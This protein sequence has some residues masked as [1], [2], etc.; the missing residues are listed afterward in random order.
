MEHK[1]G[2]LGLEKRFTYNE[3]VNYISKDPDKI[4][5]PNRTAT[6]DWDSIFRVNFDNTGQALSQADEASHSTTPGTPPYVP[7]SER[8]PAPGPPPDD[9]REAPRPAWWQHP[10]AAR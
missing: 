9:E 5:Y 8:P 7:P 4:V 3:L 10:I 2:P 1:L 6:I